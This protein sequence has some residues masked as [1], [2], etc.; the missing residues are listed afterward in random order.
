MDNI[1]ESPRGN[2]PLAVPKLRENKTLEYASASMVKLLE[3]HE[4]YEPVNTVNAFR[5]SHHSRIFDTKFGSPRTNSCTSLQNHRSRMSPSPFKMTRSPNFLLRRARQLIPDHKDLINERE[6]A[7][8]R[9]DLVLAAH[10]NASRPHT[11][12]PLSRQVHNLR[13]EEDQPTPRLRSSKSMFHLNNHNPDDIITSYDEEG[14][15]SMLEAGEISHRGPSSALH[16]GSSSQCAEEPF[17]LVPRVIV[18]P[19]IKALDNEATS[20]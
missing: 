8:N 5:P 11:P 15:H 17:T 13:Q 14:S 20:L 7:G 16:S 6:R 3:G 19:E 4:Q 1:P 12:T 18:T 9:K 2:T 10:A